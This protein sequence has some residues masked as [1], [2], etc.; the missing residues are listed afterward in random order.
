MKQ[1]LKRQIAIALVILLLL[2]TA[3]Q[4]I[5][6][7]ESVIE[8]LGITI[9]PQ[10][11]GFTDVDPDQWYA[12]YINATQ[13]HGI[14]NGIGD[15]LFA[16]NANFTRAEA[17]VTLY[18][19]AGSPE[20]T[21]TP[22]FSDVPET[23]PLWYRDAVI[24]ASEREIVLGNDGAFYPYDLLTREA[25]AAI[26]YR[27]TQYQGY[28]IPGGD[29]I[30]A[31][32]I[33]WNEISDW[34]LT[35]FSW[36]FTN[37]L[38]RGI[39]DNQVAPQETTIRAQAAAVLIRFGVLA[40][41]W[42]MP[43]EVGELANTIATTME[44]VPAIMEMAS[45]A[46]ATVAIVDAQTGFT[47]TQGFGYA[48]AQEQTLVTED[49]VFPLA[50]I[51]K[52]FTAVAVMQLVEEGL[53]DL[54]RPI[55]YYLPDFSIAPSPT[56]G[57]YRNITARMLLSHTS[58]ILTNMMGYGIATTE[59]YAGW[60]NNL[61]ENLANYAMLA[62]ENTVFT[63]ANN[64]FDLLGVLVAALSGDDNF[65]DDFIAYTQENIFERLGMSHSSFAITETIAPYLAS[66]HVDATTVDES[67]YFN[68]LATGGVMSSA[69][70]MAVFMHTLLGDGGQLLSQS[71]L[72]QIF[73]VH[74]F[75]FSASL[76]GIR[77]GLG[78]MFRT[79]GN[80]FESVG[81]GGTLVHYHSDMVFDLDSGIGV[82]ISFNSI[83]GLPL[84][85]AVASDLLQ[86]AV[87]EQTGT[88]NLQ[89]PRADADA[90]PIT[91]PIAQL[92]ALTGL[93]ISSGEHYVI[94][95]NEGV[96]YFNLPTVPSIPPLPLTPLSDGSFAVEF[97]GRVWFNPMTV[98]GEEV[99]ALSIGNLGV[100]PS[101]FREEM[102]NFLASEEFVD[103]WMG[104][105]EVVNEGIYRSLVTHFISGVDAFGLAYFQS[106]N[107]HNF[108]PIS[109]L[110]TGLADWVEV[111]GYQDIVR[112]EDGQVVSFVVLGKQ[113]VRV[114]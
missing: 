39:S 82:F 96:L 104:V 31:H 41:Y 85:G 26:M 76:G 91:L 37:G 8:S 17:V 108:N 74:D 92:E 112:N 35:Y 13:E 114:S 106:V 56:G 64:G 48:N 30:P 25:F 49:T 46:G 28:E 34:A 42:E 24:W 45:I 109:L 58:G 89:A 63:Y 2:P 62:P 100:A 47:W 83:T 6:P 107:L 1:K 87:Q 14:M 67:L 59:S 57:D 51:S 4:A 72:D 81:H 33:D 18:R 15:N 71:S 60:I 95:L 7:E 77:Y 22:V 110:P 11:G 70:D 113:F 29:S 36:A 105:F 79:A 61:L 19:M 21:F 68:F 16:P 50:S 3:A 78:V 52:T 40:Q 93:Y 97:L 12:I 86:L 94:S 53:L 9:A 75:D 44:A 103:E 27:Y 111:I 88:L 65:Y 101:A 43:V 32:F 102:E 38:I 80:G 69:A 66:P 54:D 99:L 20:V 90:T 10:A 5:F 84:A 98:N 73:T 23:A 55:V